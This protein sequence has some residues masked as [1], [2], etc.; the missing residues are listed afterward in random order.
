MSCLFLTCCSDE[1]AQ[2]GAL[3]GK[4]GKKNAWVPLD[5]TKTVSATVVK[6]TVVAKAEVV[7]EVVLEDD[8][9]K[10]PSFV[11]KDYK[12]ADEIS[13]PLRQLAFSERDLADQCFEAARDAPNR[14][15]YLRLRQLGFDHNDKC[16]DYQNQAADAIFSYLNDGKDIPTLA[17]EVAAGSKTVI[18]LHLLHQAE[19][20][21]YVHWF[22]E[23]YRIHK[24]KGHK[25]WFLAGA[26]KHTAVTETPKLVQTVQ[27]VLN[28]ADVRLPHEEPRK[29]L[30]SSLLSERPDLANV[31]LKQLRVTSSE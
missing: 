14:S 26:G 16:G 20:E 27:G 18:D 6:P 22:I 24:K 23:E 19:V 15:E 5:L 30:V 11:V 2:S 12:K 10:D 28:H 9:H 25:V 8:Y 13:A 21:F 7:D 17:A 4:K 1:V 31:I 29:G 3:G